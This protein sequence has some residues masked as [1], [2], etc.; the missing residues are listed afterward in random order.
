MESLLINI[1]IGFWLVAFGAM[2]VFPFIIESRAATG[3]TQRPVDDQ[4]LSIQ[5]V[6]MVERNRHD[7]GQPLPDAE[8][9]HRQAA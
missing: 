3:R 6:A 5:P 1:I 7:A 8:P 9:V 2:A 4:V